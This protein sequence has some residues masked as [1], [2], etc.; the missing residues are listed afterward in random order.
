[1]EHLES[2]ANTLGFHMP[3]QMLNRY[4]GA[5]FAVFYG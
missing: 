1:M 3:Q 2:A 5:K 4:A